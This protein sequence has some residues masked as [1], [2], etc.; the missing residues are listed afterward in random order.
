MHTPNVFIHLMSACKIYYAEFDD[1]EPVYPPE[2]RRWNDWV[3][4]TKHHNPFMVFKCGT[5][6]F[7]V[8]RRRKENNQWGYLVRWP[9]PSPS[10]TMVSCDSCHEVAALI[11]K[12]RG[13]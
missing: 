13:E 12:N 2:D 1:I 11:R 6:V 10:Q 4:A 3:W 8:S 7:S 5:Q 9:F